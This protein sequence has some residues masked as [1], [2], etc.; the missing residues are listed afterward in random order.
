MK[1]WCTMPM[2]AA[3]ASAGELKVTS[4]PSKEIVPPSGRYIP[5]KMLISVDLPAPFSPI[6]A[7]TSPVDNFRL[8]SSLATTPGNFLVMPRSSSSITAPPWAQH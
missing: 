3:I 6:N 5:Y 2:P 1:C 8:T 7:K 4:L